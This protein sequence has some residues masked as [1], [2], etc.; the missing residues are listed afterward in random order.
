M[1]IAIIGAGINGLCVALE[2]AKRGHNVIVYEKNKIL[3]QTSSASTKLLHGGLRYLENYDF[4]LVKESLNAR[5]WWLRNVPN[6]TKPIELHLPLYKNSNR[7]K[8]KYKLG[9]WLYDKLAGNKKIKNHYWLN[10]SLFIKKNKFLIHQMLEGGFVFY[11][12]QMLDYELGCWVANEAKKNGAIIKENHNII[13]FNTNGNIDYID[14]LNK[15]NSKNLSSESFDYIINASGSYVEQLLINNNIKPNYNIDHIRGSHIIIDR[16]IPHGYLFEYPNEKRI[17]FVLPYKNKTLI[18]T[19]EERQTLLDPIR[20]SIKEK[21]YLIKGYNYYFS[22]KIKI[23][24]IIDDFSGLRPLIKSNDSFTKS[25]REYAIQKNNKLI[26]LYGGKWTT[27]R[28][29]AKNVV[30]N[31]NL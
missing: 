23:N 15:K 13:N 18:G 24:D 3:E 2:A 27:S 17:F 28:S 22:S 7:S 30:N 10:K 5:D 11:D 26:S 25:S 12:G 8:F 6:L 4:K 31:M 16:Y 21:E 20:C 14:K 9:L 1:K 19:T 29:L